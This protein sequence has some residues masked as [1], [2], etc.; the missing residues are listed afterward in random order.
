MIFA[1]QSHPGNRPNL[2]Y[3]DIGF[4]G[5]TGPNKPMA[6]PFL[7]WYAAAALLVFLIVGLEEIPWKINV[8]RVARRVRVAARRRGTTTSVALERIR[9]QTKWGGMVLASF[10]VGAS[11]WFLVNLAQ[12]R[13]TDSGA[14]VLGATLTL[15]LCFL[16]FMFLVW[17]PRLFHQVERTLDTA[18]AT[19]NSHASDGVPPHGAGP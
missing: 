4:D 3:R 13:F 15:G 17:A 8:M 12:R 2:G 6:D 18:S 10:A 5:S 16:S 7:L 9:R 19:A 11:T 1:R 14:V